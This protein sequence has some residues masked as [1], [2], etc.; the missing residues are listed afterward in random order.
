M[1]RA[2]E[3]SGP[4]LSVE[5]LPSGGT[6]GNQEVAQTLLSRLSNV[7]FGSVSFSLDDADAQL[8]VLD[9][10]GLVVDP[11]TSSLNG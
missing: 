2:A 8:V 9:A 1:Q 4:S 5:E 10:R 7:I 11:N 6:G 3:I